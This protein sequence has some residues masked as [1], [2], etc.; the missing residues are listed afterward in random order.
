MSRLLLSES[1]LCC[2]ELFLCCVET[3]HFLSQDGVDRCDVGAFVVELSGEG[4]E[5]V[6][7]DCYFTI[8]R[9]LVVNCS[10]KFFP[11]FG[12][13]T[14]LGLDFTFSGTIVIFLTLE[15]LFVLF[16]IGLFRIKFVFE[17]AKLFSSFTDKFIS[18][19]T[20]FNRVLPL[21]I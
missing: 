14:V 11:K 7:K 9:L 20:V 6:P 19:A 4:G 5:L 15:S 13:F 10:S 3:L 16:Q 17:L 12:K 2:G 18:T 1:F 21:K 8:K